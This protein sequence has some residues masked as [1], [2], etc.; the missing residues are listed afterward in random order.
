[1]EKDFEGIINRVD[2][3]EERISELEDVTLESSRTHT[4]THTQKQKSQRLCVVWT[5]AKG[6]IQHVGSGN[7][8]SEE[9]PKETG[10]IFEK[11]MMENSLKLM[12]DT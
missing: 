5:T 4:H 6:I 8:Q 1:M 10:Q 9:K 12:S 7:I 3:A 11:I 2:T